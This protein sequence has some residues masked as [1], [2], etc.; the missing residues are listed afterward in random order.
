MPDALSI[1][2]EDGTSVAFT[3]KADGVVML[4]A[5]GALAPTVTAIEIAPEDVEAIR[6]WL[7]KHDAAKRAETAKEAAAPRRKT[8]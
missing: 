2:Y 8:A 3:H 7:G 1:K 6:A 5:R 4:E